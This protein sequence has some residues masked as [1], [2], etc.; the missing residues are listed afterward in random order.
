MLDRKAAILACRNLLATLSVCTTGSTTLVATATGY[1]RPAGS[2]VDDGFEVGMEILP[3]GFAT[4]TR[5][6]IKNVVAGTI[7][8][9]SAVT[10][11]ASGGSRSLTVGQPE[12]RAYTNV[13]YDPKQA[14][15]RPYTEEEWLPGTSTV[16]GLGPGA[17]IIHNPIY[18]VKLYGLSEKG[19]AALAAYS[20]AILLLFKP[21]TS[22]A[23]SASQVLEVKTLTP[24]FS[25]GITNPS[26]LPG[27]ALV[28]VTVPLWAQTTIPT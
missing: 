5:Q 18:V 14:A 9:E 27:R 28:T 24:P 1:T 23:T 21:N 17:R 26:S 12:Y 7:L 11:E 6:V 20:D 4:N 16:T 3:A 22:I 13:K 25:S 10:A 19:E 15:G 8:T 2:F